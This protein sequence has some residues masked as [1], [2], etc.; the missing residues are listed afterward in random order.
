M[1][2]KKAKEY[3]IG[4]MKKMLGSDFKTIQG[5]TFHSKGFT[6][7]EVVDTL[8]IATDI[9]LFPD[10]KY[11]FRFMLDRYEVLGAREMLDIIRHFINWTDLDNKF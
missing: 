3:V 8:L 2:Y 11:L 10:G 7:T 5:K 6:A 9:I 4:E 1:N